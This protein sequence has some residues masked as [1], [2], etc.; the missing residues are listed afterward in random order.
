MALVQANLAHTTLNDG[1]KSQLESG[2]RLKV[3][4]KEEVV[5]G[6][7]EE[8]D[9]VGTLEA[10]HNVSFLG[11]L[12]ILYGNVSTDLTNPFPIQVETINNPLL[13]H[14]LSITLVHNK[15]SLEHT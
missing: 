5:E 3:L 1:K 4:E 12:V 8:E 10:G 11:K 2:G 7:S 9:Q 15:L 6:L 13:L 14:H